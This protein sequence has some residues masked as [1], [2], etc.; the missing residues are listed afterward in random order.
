MAIDDNTSYE[1]TGSQIKD[2][3]TKIK[4][5][6]DSSS[7]AS[8]AT[9]GNYNDLSNL[10]TP[11][12]VN[13]GTLTIKQNGTT[14]DTFTANSSDDKT[15]DI[16]TITA[17]TVAPVEEVGAI[18][19]SM[20]NWSSV[21]EKILDKIYPIG[22]I[23]MSATLDTVAK[24]QEAFGGTWVAW[25]SGR[26][27][28]GVDTSQTEFKSAE[29][30]G[31]NKTHTHGL[32]NGYALLVL[33]GNGQVRY[34]ERIVATWTDNYYHPASGNGGGSSDSQGYGTNLAGSTDAGSSLQPYITCYMYKRTA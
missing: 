1:L 8:V 26:V 27:P 32:T 34:Q 2:F 23:Y 7:L 25:G 31:G 11:P 28:V 22:S 12:T 30:T 29:K 21:M 19:A 10:P 13:N 3:A 6:A 33:K 16:Q 18:T 15:V 14:V 20:I 24:V 5:K 17:E 4:S 9:S